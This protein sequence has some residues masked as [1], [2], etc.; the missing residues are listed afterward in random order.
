MLKSSQQK[1]DLVFASLTPNLQ[2]QL[3]KLIHAH[4]PIYVVDQ[5]LDHAECDFLIESARNSFCPA[6]VVGEGEGVISP[7]RTSSTCY[8]ARE[9]LPEYMRKISLLTGKNPEHCELPQVGQY[10]P[11]QQYMVR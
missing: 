3:P 5:F 4:P 8:M 1:H 7:A 6:P 2:K 11:S 10:L 9:D